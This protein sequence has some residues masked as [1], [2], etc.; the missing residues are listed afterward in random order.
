MEGHRGKG[1]KLLP[2]GGL[3]NMPCTADVSSKMRI[4]HVLCVVDLTAGRLLVPLIRAFT[5][6]LGLSGFRSKWE[7]RW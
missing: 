4:K 5:Q 7:V 2:A 6:K 1:R 3:V